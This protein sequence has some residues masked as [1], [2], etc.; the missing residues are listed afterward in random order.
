M[1]ETAVEN[2]LTRT[3]PNALERRANLS[4]GKQFVG[5]WNF[6]Q[7]G[8]VMVQQV[9]DVVATKTYKRN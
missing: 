3:G 6:S 2:L 8:L 1:G 5:K 4:T 7:D 9:E